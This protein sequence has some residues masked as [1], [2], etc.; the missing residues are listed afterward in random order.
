M[1]LRRSK[2]YGPGVRRIALA[3]AGFGRMDP[4]TSRRA[5]KAAE[6]EVITEVSAALGNT[7]TVAR[8]SYI[9]PRVIDAFAEGVTISRALARAAGADTEEE[10]RAIT[11]R[12]VIRLLGGASR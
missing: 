1:R 6:K 10:R 8:A 7:P 4:P 5:R 11:E 3:A 9:D 2:P 12:A